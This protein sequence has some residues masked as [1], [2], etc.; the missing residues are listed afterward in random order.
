MKATGVV[1]RVDDLGRFA[2]KKLPGGDGSS[3]GMIFL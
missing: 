3:P 1:S 2:H